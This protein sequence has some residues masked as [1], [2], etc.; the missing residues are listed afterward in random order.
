M[1]EKKVDFCLAVANT[2]AIALFGV[3]ATIYVEVRASLDNAAKSAAGDLV[4]HSG[5]NGELWWLLS[6]VAIILGVM[7]TIMYLKADEKTN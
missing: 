3:I 4:N 1:S 5:M 7:T 6:T 2:L